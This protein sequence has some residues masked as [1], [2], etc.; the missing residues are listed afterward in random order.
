[1]AVSVK[2][3]LLKKDEI[4]GDGLASIRAYENTMIDISSFEAGISDA[5]VS[6]NPS[7]IIKDNTVYKAIRTYFDLDKNTRILLFK[8][9]GESF[10]IISSS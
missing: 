2:A 10:D 6:T 8:E 9:S 4:L 7:Y 3:L 5:T 1:M